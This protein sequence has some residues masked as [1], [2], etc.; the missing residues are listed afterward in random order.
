MEPVGFHG[1]SGPASSIID[2]AV[3]WA[4]RRDTAPQDWITAVEA[5][6]P[7]RRGE[8]MHGLYNAASYYEQENQYNLEKVKAKEMS[9]DQSTK[10]INKLGEK[11]EHQKMMIGGLAYLG[12]MAIIVALS[13]MDY[14]K[15]R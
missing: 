12:L 10:I 9:A 6:S 13:T 5:E 15:N 4:N 1:Q 8:A 11:V 7:Q 14:R 2:H 3:N